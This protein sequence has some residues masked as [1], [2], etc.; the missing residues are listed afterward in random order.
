[1]TSFRISLLPAALG[2]LLLLSACETSEERA[3]K[4]YQSGLALLQE[5]DVERGLVELRNVFKLNGTHK[6]ARRLYADTIMARGEVAEA[7][8]QYLRL[9]EQYPDEIEVRWILAETSISL[10]NW[11]EVRRHGE[12]A[13]ALDP[14]APRS[15]VLKTATDYYQIK[16]TRPRAELAPVIETAQALLAE[17]GEN[18][19]LLRVMI[20]YELAGQNRQAALP[21]LERALAS[22]PAV[23]DLSLLKFRLLAEGGQEEAAN[24]YIQ[25]MVT[26]FPDSDDIR[27]L[28]VNWYFM[29]Q[30][31]DGAESFL[32]A[33]AD[34]PDA[35]VEDHVAV[36]QV[37]GQAR[38]RDASRAELARLITRFAGTEDGL[39]F[40]SMDA[41]MVFEDGEQET[42]IA[43]LRAALDAAPASDRKR[44][45]QTVLAR[46]L[47]TAGDR[48][49]AQALVDAVLAEDG[50][51]VPALK[52]RAGWLIDADRPG[53]AI[54]AL[55]TAL[56]QAPNDPE[57]LTLMA[58]AHEREGNAE[59]AV[60][61]LALA[62]EASNSAPDETLRYV[63]A[64]LQQDR[65]AAAESVLENALRRSP[66]NIAL[67][68]VMGE[69]QIGNQN[70]PRV[71]E[72]IAQLERDVTG[73]GGLAAKGLELT[74]MQS[75]NRVDDSL[76]TLISGLAGTTGSTEATRSVMLVVQTQIRANRLDEARSFLDGV[77][78]EQPDNPSLRLTSAILDG[79]RND[80]PAAEQQYLSL[81]ADYPQSEEPVRLYLRLLSALGREDE[82]RP[83]LMAARARMPEA[84]ALAMMEA[85]LLQ[86]EGDFEGAIAIFEDLYK[87][88]SGNPLLANNLASLLATHRTDADSLERA[89]AISR[90]LRTIDVPAVQDTYGWIEYRRGNYAEALPYLQSA[91]D[92]LPQEPLVQYHLGMTLAALERPAEAR[93]ALE[94]ALELA[95]DSP[96]P[97]FRTARETLETLPAASE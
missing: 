59:L 54:V 58:Y 27:R 68:Q 1:M 44:E 47:N 16:T 60:E 89:V 4:F 97:Q 64:L 51:L 91:A 57:V 70:W 78:A 39:L 88:N 74:M 69:L 19:T 34:A 29:R 95:G 38:G 28:L 63:T 85:D 93:T 43:Q 6:E 22:D 66:G 35:T 84:N 15:R 71:R 65:R 81:I 79:V 82:I 92:G 80:I 31:F 90:R 42:A 21:Y 49:G 86:I 14:D 46:M 3:E 87:T 56:G 62:V 12:A 40:T 52:L 37:I 20:D 48:D 61:R 9:I 24:A 53:E 5:G 83:V 36:L 17:I 55:R 41:A 72:I 73:P 33:R 50:N 8:G 77:L 2:A 13:F 94:R 10:G 30:D 76:D 32:R 18:Q 45:A 25:E 26:L 75:Q 96:L 7:M 23:Y 67:L 11:D